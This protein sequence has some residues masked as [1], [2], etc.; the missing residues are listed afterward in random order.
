MGS[1]K[2]TISDDQKIKIGQSFQFFLTLRKINFLA[3]HIFDKLFEQME[4]SALEVKKK[5]PFFF[6]FSF[7]P[8]FIF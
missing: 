6:F 5:S 1:M 3:C 8:F 7:F 2:Y 4:E